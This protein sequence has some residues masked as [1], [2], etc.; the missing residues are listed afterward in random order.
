MTPMFIPHILPH[1]TKPRPCHMSHRL[2]LDLCHMA[3]KLSLKGHM[4]F[5]LGHVVAKP[6][7]RPRPCNVVTKFR[8]R[9]KPCDVALRLGLNIGHMVPRLGLGHM[10]LLLNI[11][12]GHT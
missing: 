6:R 3:L 12:L 9:P 10:A 1:G 7:L 8:L 4:A 5:I 2:G 11:N